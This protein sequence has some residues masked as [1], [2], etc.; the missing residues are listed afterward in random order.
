MKN[1]HEE[2]R[3]RVDLNFLTNYIIWC[4]RSF[5]R[6]FFKFSN[7]DFSSFLGKLLPS[8]FS[9]GQTGQ[10]HYIAFFLSER[11]IMRLPCAFQCLSEFVIQALWSWG[12]FSI[13]SY[14]R[15][16]SSFTIC[17]VVMPQSDKSSVGL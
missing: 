6:P 8:N 12:M 5:I 10:T 2:G 13:L 9:T 3:I 15:D 7:F 17:S 4:F 11:V 16:S 1:T 14:K